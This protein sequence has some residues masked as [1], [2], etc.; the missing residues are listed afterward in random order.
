MTVARE[1]HVP[2]PFFNCNVQ[3]GACPLSENVP[4]KVITKVPL[5]V[6]PAAAVKVNEPPSFPVMASAEVSVVGTA[7]TVPVPVE[8]HVGMSVEAIL[9]VM[10]VFPPWLKSAPVVRVTSPVWRQFVPPPKVESR[11]N[12]LAVASNCKPF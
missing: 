12:A 11:I 4:A 7:G 1:F 8:V 5:E 3:D 10:Q 9:L 6:A 2:V